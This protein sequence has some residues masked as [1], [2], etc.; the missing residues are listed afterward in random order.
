MDFFVFTRTNMVN[1]DVQHFDLINYVCNIRDVILNTWL[2]AGCCVYSIWNLL[3]KILI[4]R[5]FDCV[6]LLIIV[7]CFSWPV[8]SLTGRTD[9][10]V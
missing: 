2:P 7:R 1:N 6:F 10:S 5:I 8:S 3:V 9:L 4:M